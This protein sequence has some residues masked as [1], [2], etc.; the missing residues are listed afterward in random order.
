MILMWSHCRH[1]LTHDVE[2]PVRTFTALLQALILASI[3]HPKEFHLFS[4]IFPPFEL[5][6]RRFDHTIFGIKKTGKLDLSSFVD[7][8]SPVWLCHSWIIWGTLLTVARSK[9]T[10]GLST[11]VTWC[12]LTCGT[13]FCLA[14]PIEQ[15][16]QGFKLP[17]VSVHPNYFATFL[18]VSS[19]G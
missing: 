19:P 7:H 3:I 14:L 17:H 2:L 16:L 15:A 10:L 6:T 5:F 1:V 9:N 18:V 13:L 8:N 11:V 12:S 4:R